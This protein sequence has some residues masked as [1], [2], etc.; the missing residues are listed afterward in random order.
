LD[1]LF[2]DAIDSEVS[3]N[4]VRNKP[5]KSLVGDERESDEGRSQWL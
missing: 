2:L 4:E 1:R 5:G 3:S